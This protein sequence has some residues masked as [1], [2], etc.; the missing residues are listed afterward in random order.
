MHPAKRHVVENQKTLETDD[1]ARPGADNA[2]NA[3]LKPLP[4]YI[5][6][7][8]APPDAIKWRVHY[9]NEEGKLLEKGPYTPHDPE[10]KPEPEAEDTE[11]LK[12]SVFEILI[13]VTIRD[14]IETKSIRTEAA[15]AKAGQSQEGEQGSD[16]GAVKPQ[17]LFKIQSVNSCEMIIRSSY[18]VEALRSV[19]KYYPGQ[20][21]AGETVTIPE[22]YYI[23]LHHRKE[24]AAY[25][26]KDI[27]GDP[28]RVNDIG[29]E[30]KSEIEGPD[31][32]GQG[33]FKVLQAYL[34]ARWKKKIE[35]EETRHALTPPT[36]TFEMLWMLFKPGTRV[37]AKD[38]HDETAGYIV[39]SL[40]NKDDKLYVN[41][42]YLEF[43][44]GH[45][46]SFDSL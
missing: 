31:S 8:G 45:C 1:I 44:G 14:I 36:A 19:V 18:L 24:L 25:F 26:T 32:L 13:H 12:P 7:N 10:L 16:V 15:A 34:D 41:L 30:R 27:Q 40:T 23:L 28:Q 5:S 46:S 2:E 29:T 33:H 11:P 21:L 9:E 38:P 6:L 3:I 39:R 37:F 17:N 42:W 20:E 35:R 22:P 4:P 43:D